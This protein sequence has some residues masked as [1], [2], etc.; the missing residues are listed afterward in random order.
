MVSEERRC[1]KADAS[2]KDKS[3]EGEKMKIG[4]LEFFLE[5]GETMVFDG[6]GC[7]LVTSYEVIECFG[8]VEE[9]LEG[10]NLSIIVKIPENAKLKRGDFVKNT[11]EALSRLLEYNDVVEI[12]KDEDIYKVDWPEDCVEENRWQSGWRDDKGIVLYFGSKNE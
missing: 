8:D 10:V 3:E 11:E 12:R 7:S 4:E 6:E 5:N 9:N 1:P 2:H